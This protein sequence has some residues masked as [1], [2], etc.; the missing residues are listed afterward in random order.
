MR[1]DAA[2]KSRTR[3]ER[4]LRWWSALHSLSPVSRLAI[5]FV[6]L[7][8]C[9]DDSST[10]PAPPPPP[11]EM[12][13][14][15]AATFTM[16][17]PADEPGR[18]PEETQHQVALTRAFY[19]SA[20]EVTQAEWQT[21]MGWNESLFSRDHRPVELVT[22]CDC[23]SYCNQ[24]STLDGYDHAYVI[25]NATYDGN[26][27]TSGTV[28]WDQSANGY[29]LLTEAE[30]EYA[31][32]ATSTTALCNGEITNLGCK[33]IDPSLDLVGWCCGNAGRRT[34]DVGLKGA[35]AWGLKDMHGNV[36]EWCWDWHGTYPT[37]AVTNPTGPASGSYR[38]VRGGTWGLAALYCRSACRI[39]FPP[40][41]HF[42]FVGLRLA[43]T[44]P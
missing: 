27:I 20:T 23:V 14:V 38:V 10:S 29:R 42:T 1:V 15:P 34:H 11:P 33:P 16:G 28:T 21:V 32:R 25:S 18:V 4:W 41:M 37:G 35:N 39:Y 26:H 30:W 43:R 19:V 12:V 6:V 24:R 40:V 31:C 8:G 36:G 2:R 13:L 44:A 5:V 22:W 17:S 7:V 3:Q 9:G